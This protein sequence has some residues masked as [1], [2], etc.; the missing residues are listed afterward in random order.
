MNDDLLKAVG[1][2][3]A[4][5]LR[6]KK[7]RYLYK[8]PKE[9]RALGEVLSSKLEGNVLT[10]EVKLNEYGIKQMEKLIGKPF[11]EWDETDM[12]IGND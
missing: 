4:K 2:K 8:P 6:G 9:S 5:I 3:S 1:A 7:K 12:E 11:S 10:K